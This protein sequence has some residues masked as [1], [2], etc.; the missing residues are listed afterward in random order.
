MIVIAV[1]Y[2]SSTPHGRRAQ[3][4]GLKG[5][6]KK[7]YDNKDCARTGGERQVRYL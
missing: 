7:L 1:G 2:E 4:L 5:N 3:N 6:P